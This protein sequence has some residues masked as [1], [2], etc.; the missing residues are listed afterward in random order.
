[1]LRKMKFL[2]GACILSFAAQSYSVETSNGCGANCVSAV[3]TGSSLIYTWYSEDGTPVKS[4][5]VELPENA[6]ASSTEISDGVLRQ[7]DNAGTTL[8][9]DGGKG[10]VEY[11]TDTY[12]TETEY[13]IIST[14]RVYNKSGTLIS[15]VVTTSR[16]PIGKPRIPK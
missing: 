8:D 12:E 7:D 6:V 5:L 4:F 10:R 3:K 2:L 1:M 13:V 16:I 9:F 14:M 15:V 11:T